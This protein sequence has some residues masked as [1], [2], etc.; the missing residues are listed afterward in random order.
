MTRRSAGRQRGSATVEAAVLVPATMLTLLVVLQVGLWA[1]AVESVQQVADRAA[2]AAAALGAGP[3]DGQQAARQALA[4]VAGH[5]VVDPSVTVTS[6]GSNAD[7]VVV[8]GQVESIVPGWHPV[9]TARRQ[10]TVQR[11]RSGTGP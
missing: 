3:A 9:V 7:D 5:L 2:R 8:T 10:A 11:F 1:L 6:S 4:G